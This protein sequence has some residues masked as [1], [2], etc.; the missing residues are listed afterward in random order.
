MTFSHLTHT[1]DGGSHSQIKRNSYGMNAT[2]TKAGFHRCE[3][4]HD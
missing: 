1:K 3:G 4:C 2:E